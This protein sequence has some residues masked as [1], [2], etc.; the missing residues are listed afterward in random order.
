MTPAVPAAPAIRRPGA[1]VAVSVLAA[2][3]ANFDLQI[4]NLALPVIGDAF[5]VG[6]ST[7]AWAVNAYVLPFAVSILAVG[8]L[9][10]RYGLRPC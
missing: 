5:D 7:L 3:T 1:L 8:R 4:V 10:D 9:G 6:Q 2:F